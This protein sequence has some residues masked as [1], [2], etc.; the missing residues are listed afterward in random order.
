M[1]LSTEQAALAL[2]FAVALAGGG[3]ALHYRHEA[4]RERAAAQHLGQQL[5]DTRAALEHARTRADRLAGQATALD[6]QLGTAKTRTTAT[7]A[8]STHLQRELASVKSTLTE[9]EQRE[10]ALLAEIESLRRQSPQETP[11]PVSSAS[12]PADPGA[13]AALTRRLAALEAQLTELLARALAEPAG[14]SESAAEL[15]SAPL[16][17]VRVG[18]ADAFVVLDYGADHG[19]TVGCEAVLVRGT[20]AVGRVQISDVRARFSVAQ[21]LPPHKGQLQPGDI[22]LLAQ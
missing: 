5:N 12:V 10:V 21:V 6:T 18:P 13:A 16:Q 7:E 22:V 2:A 9:R 15:P 1:R 11:V 17:V 20:S 8:R 3:V 19:A 4:Q 14:S